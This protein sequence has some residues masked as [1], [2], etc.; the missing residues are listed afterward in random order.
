M[1]EKKDNVELICNIGE[2]AGLFE[3]SESLSE[4]LQTVVSVV[5]YHMSASV[6]SVYLLDESGTNLELIANQGLNPAVVGKVRISRHEGI[7]GLALK[8]LRT[9]RT[10]HAS[11]HA[12][13]KLIPGSDEEKYESFLAAPIL[14]GLTR[15]GVL[16]VQDT[17]PDYFTKND[18]NALQAIAAQLAASIENAKLFMSLHE[19]DDA[20]PEEP[21]DREVSAKD[22]YHGA[23]A[24]KGIARGRATIVGQTDSFLRLTEEMELRHCTADEFHDA[25]QKSEEQIEA[26]QKH[27]DE[28]YADVTALIF[29]A[30]LLILKDQMFSGE[31]IDLMSAGRSPQA[32]ITEVVNRYV[33]L[34][35][36]NKNPRF[37]EKVQDVKDV[38]HRILHNLLH[39]EDIAPDYRGEIVIV[40]ELLPSDLVK[41]ATQHVAGLIIVG[42]G[43]TSHVSILARSMEV[44][45]ILLDDS[46]IFDVKEGTSI[47]LDA[48]SGTAYVQPSQE[49]MDQY[50]DIINVHQQVAFEDAD[51]PETTTTRDGHKIQLLANIN[52]LNELNLA[53]KFHAEGIG[54]YRSEF[55]FVVRR[56]FP[57]EEEQYRIYRKVVTTMKPL[58]IT[59]RTLD[60]GGDKMV[61]HASFLDEANPF[62]GLRALRF[63]LRNK[64]VFRVQLRAMLRSALDV[65]LCIMFPMVA[66]VDEFLEACELTREC[67]GELK[68]ESVPHC[69]KPMFGPMIELPS[70]VET[71]EELAAEADFLCI[72]TNDLVQYTLGVD[73]TNESIADY[74]VPHHPA[75]LRSLKRIVS[76]GARAG[77]PVS[78]CGDMA[79]DPSMLP[80]LIGIGITRVSIDVRLIRKVQQTIGGIDR[81][82]ASTLADEMLSKGRISELIPLVGTRANE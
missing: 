49:V 14:R 43:V 54:L 76:A 29:S 82:E 63:T 46:S 64:D 15:I 42:G 47:L 19:R 52:L 3:R 68:E 22:L 9:I 6:C 66:S 71:V 53:K 65:D 39:G 16:V 60:I 38:G 55:P 13:Y 30:H 2:L 56:G 50:L 45:L 8:E 57:S 44:P 21:V 17:E 59:M 5:A 78:I 80:F 67:I 10:G 72:G 40:G 35:S 26:L 23:C 48:T 37:Q 18:A 4:F 70:A 7:T 20:P 61:A 51:I 28:G 58:P 79:G 73:R 75:V 77:I 12:S 11:L 36:K 34:F 31:M 25:L 24:S 69:G 27:L 74:Y 32:A 41:F 33:Q 81:K 1:A 62:L